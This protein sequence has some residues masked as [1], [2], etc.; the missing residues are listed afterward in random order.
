M[1]IPHPIALQGRGLAHGGSAEE[2]TEQLSCDTPDLHSIED[3]NIRNLREHEDH[4]LGVQ[5]H[6]EAA[7][8]RRLGSGQDADDLTRSGKSRGNL[9]VQVTLWSALTRTR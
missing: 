3:S 7:P 4:R 6:S 8:E 2:R 1:F 9:T 5:Q